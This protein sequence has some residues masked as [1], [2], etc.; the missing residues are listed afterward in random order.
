[1]VVVNNDDLIDGN[2]DN[3][4]LKQLKVIKYQRNFIAHG[5]REA[6]YPAVEYPLDAIAGTLDKVI[7]EIEK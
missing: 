3:H 4:F 7:M 5:K 6:Q 2:I 1:M